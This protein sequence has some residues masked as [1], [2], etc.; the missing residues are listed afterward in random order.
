MSFDL[1]YSGF[2][3]F[4]DTLHNYVILIRF[5]AYYVKILFSAFQK[6]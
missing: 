5:S 6:Y 1:F 2:K 4:K 3:G